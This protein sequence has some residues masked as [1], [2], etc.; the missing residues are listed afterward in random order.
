MDAEPVTERD[1]RAGILHY[2]T[3]AEPQDLDPHTVT[4]VPEHR[5]TSVLFEGLVDLD[6]ETL[7]P[8]PAVA[9]SWS[10][11]EDETVYTF[12]LRDTAQWSNG[13][14]VT[15]HDFVYAWQ[16]ILTPALGSEYAYMLY[17]LKNARDFHEGALTDFG[18]VGAKAMDGRT[19]EVTLGNPT[20]YF[21]SMQ[22][23]YTWYPVH[24]ATIERFGAMDERGTRWTRAGNLVGNGAFM[25]ERWEP[26]RVITV[27][28]NPRYWNKDAVELNGIHFHPID[29][30]L[31][32][33]LLFRVNRLHVT[34]TIPVNK[35]ETYESDRPGALRI[36]PYLGTYFYRINVT[37]S[38]F[39][40]ARVRRALSMAIDREDLVRNVV[41][42][43][44]KSA[45]FF[46]PPDTAGYT[47]ETRVAFDPEE[48]R[49]LLS[50]AGYPE[51][52]GFPRTEILYNT[53]DNH[54]Q[55]AEAAQAMWR[56]TLGITVTLVNQEWKVYLDSMNQ[57][58]Y[59]IARSGWIGDY[60]DPIN[61]LECFTTGN[62]NN[63]TGFSSTRYDGLIAQSLQT[64]DAEARHRILQE[65]EGLLLEEAPIIPVYFYTNAY[66]VAPQVR[67]LYPNPLG[68]VSFKDLSLEPG[69]QR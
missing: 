64:A 6:P 11:S 28:K 61:F 69:G 57:L 41:R 58:D 51:G 63:R 24:R 50:A 39:T 53:S 34:A 38:P 27:V 21:L 54:K 1:A 9:E 65:A 48:A 26:D 62:G 52:K 56:D 40:D 32:E 15:A 35:L 20:P 49:R 10:V 30:N 17:C 31:T 36:D 33:E 22:I 42:A 45:P 13:D 3:G 68:Y 44:R 46:T 25:L 5:V 8:V 66:L 47:C 19:L 67:G 37:R 12:R 18:Q 2:S 7:E 55:I 59:G 14:P 23:H 29:N 4:G 43:G 60:L 16:R